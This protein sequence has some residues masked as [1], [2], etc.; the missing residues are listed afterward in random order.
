MTFSTQL[1]PRTAPP[2]DLIRGSV[3]TN[4]VVESGPRV[5]PEGGTVVVVDAEFNFGP[6]GTDEGLRR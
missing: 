1:T 2:S 4:G 5:K 6:R 3:A